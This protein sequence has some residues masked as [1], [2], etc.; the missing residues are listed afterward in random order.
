MAKEG[1]AQIT[2]A[3]AHPTRTIGRDEMGRPIVVTIPV[4]QSEKFMDLDGNEVWVPLQTSRVPSEQCSRI[5][6]EPMRRDLIK[7]GFI[8]I[9]DCPYSTKYSDLIGGPMA[10]LPAGSMACEGAKATTLPVYSPEADAAHARQA[11]SQRAETVVPCEHYDTVRAARR[12]RS[13]REAKERKALK[14]PTA[15][16][17]SMAESVDAGVKTMIEVARQNLKEE[18]G[19]DDA[20]RKPRR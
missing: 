8:P 13:S 5:Y 4:H 10:A 18:R 7:Q 15:A 16:M 1:I 3:S 20:G 11:L 14:G 19:E 17:M 6:G 9:R 12:E 2:E